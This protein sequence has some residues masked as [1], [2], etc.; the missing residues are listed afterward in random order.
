MKRIWQ[1]L[2]DRIDAYSLRERGMMFAA[3]VLVLAMLMDAIFLQPEFA[4]EKRLSS[5]VSQNQAELRTLQE[6]IQRVVSVRQADPDRDN[7]AR[8]ERLKTRVA[9]SEAA[10]ESEQRKF[11][12]PEKMRA[13]LEEMLSRNRRVRLVELK[14]LAPT[15][16]ADAKAQ[17]EAAPKPA[18][19]VTA[20]PPAAERQIY[21]HG[22]ELTVAGSY[23][24]LLAYLQDLEKLPTQLYWGSA[25]MNAAAHPRVTLKIT[26][27]T[28]SLDKAWMNV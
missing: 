7:R 5:R 25:E 9:E 16:I 24:D 2:A 26:V 22:V 10:I 21:R 11:T 15:S 8:L 13:V 12:P 18:A 6:Q 17:P 14:T 20:K 3:A 23:L 4:R 27:Y 28:L 1:R 19:P